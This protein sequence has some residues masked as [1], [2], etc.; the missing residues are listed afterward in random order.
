M[1]RP[2]C[3]TN[4]LGSLGLWGTIGL[5]SVVL[6]TKPAEANPCEPGSGKL[7]THREI[8]VETAQGQVYGALSS[9]KREKPF[10]EPGEV[11]LTFD[12]GPMPS[13]TR[14]ILD[15]LDR[16]CVKA[17]FFMIGRMAVSYPATAR[18]VMRRGHTVGTHTQ[19]H[20]LHMR[21][22]PLKSSVDDIERGIGAV[23]DAMGQPV[24]P[25]FRFPGLADSPEMVAHLARRGI[26]TFTVDVVSNDSFISDPGRLTRE[27][28]A[29]IVKNRGGIV[30]FH[31]IK[32]STMK[33]L[34]QILD[35]LARREFRVVHIRPPDIGSVTK[36]YEGRFAAQVQRAL[37]RLPAP[38]AVATVKPASRPE[39]PATP[40]RSQPS[41]SGWATGT[42]PRLPGTEW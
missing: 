13:I 12:D 41:T 29:K 22:M 1:S 10:L 16:H 39:V 42:V 34:P 25:F 31:D 33:A 20:F 19:S 4:R 28:V 37:G 2:S 6:A 15:E 3:T 30:L 23:A 32:R 26:G 7:G 36:G 24:A 11:V 27:T 9:L 17:T 35:E 21:S 38:V 18:D 14:P 8:V 40:A 5:M